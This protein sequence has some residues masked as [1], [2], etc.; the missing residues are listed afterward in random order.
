MPRLRMLDHSAG[1]G[2][3]IPM[4]SG[5][6][7]I[8][9]YSTAPVNPGFEDQWRVKRSFSGPACH[10]NGRGSES[11][12]TITLLPG[13]MGA[14]IGE[15]ALPTR[16]LVSVIVLFGSVSHRPH[17]TPGES[18]TTRARQWKNPDDL[19]MSLSSKRNVIQPA[20][21]L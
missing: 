14:S 10:E 6:A 21:E 4:P 19:T 5:G 11:L 20:D 12:L 8:G 18:G 17:L 15:G 9:P 1:S 16:S 13:P 7:G 2:L 3:K